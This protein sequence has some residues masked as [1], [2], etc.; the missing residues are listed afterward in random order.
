MAPLRQR[1]IDDLTLYRPLLL[2][3][4]AEQSLDV[5]GHHHFFPALPLHPVGTQNLAC[6]SQ[7]LNFKGGRGTEHHWPSDE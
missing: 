7:M 2:G 4:R 3:R 5:S 6:G 1:K